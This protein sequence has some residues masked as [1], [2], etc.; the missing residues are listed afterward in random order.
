MII[1][2]N[3]LANV[4]GIFHG[5]LGFD[6]IAGFFAP[7]VECNALTAGEDD[8]AGGQ[9]KLV[10]YKKTDL[11]KILDLAPK[12]CSEF[13]PGTFAPLPLVN[14]KDGT[15]RFIFNAY[16]NM[17]GEH[18]CDQC[19]KIPDCWVNENIE[20]T[21]TVDKNCAITKW[22]SLW[23]VRAPPPVTVSCAHNDGQTLTRAD[24]RMVGLSTSCV[25]ATRNH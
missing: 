2:S 23:G 20:W 19:H 3:V 7:E 17:D 11:I 13:F 5:N 15:A 22:E 25:V 6:A 21:L 9:K 10:R 4:H 14:E 16:L 12:V 24:L 8:P 1:P 18:V